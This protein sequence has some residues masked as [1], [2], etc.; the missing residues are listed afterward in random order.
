MDILSYDLLLGILLRFRTYVPYKISAFALFATSFIKDKIRENYL[1]E[2]NNVKKGKI[3][4]DDGHKVIG[5][6]YN[7]EWQPIIT[8]I[9][10]KRENDNIKFF[11]LYLISKGIFILRDWW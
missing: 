10:V 4:G 7:I 5:L 3:S 11:S 6:T 2:V 1:K 8:R 9:A